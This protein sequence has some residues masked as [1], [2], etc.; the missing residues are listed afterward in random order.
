[1]KEKQCIKLIFNYLGLEA[2]FD[3]FE[4]P[5]RTVDSFSRQTH[6]SICIQN[7]TCRLAKYLLNPKTHPPTS[8]DGS[9]AAR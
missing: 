8:R 5:I 2:A 6:T 4:D 7:P 9:Q 3:L 1:M